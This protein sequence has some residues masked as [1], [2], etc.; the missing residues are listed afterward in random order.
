[1]AK[2]KV[3]VTGGAGFIGSHTV[4]ELANAGYEPIII[5]NFSNSEKQVIARLTQIT[6][7]PF[8][9]HELDCCNRD[10][11]TSALDSDVFGVIHFAA[12]K[13]VSASGRDPL[14]YYRNN[15][16]STTSLLSAMQQ[17]KVDNFVFSSSCTVY[18]QPD[19]LPVTEET[20]MKAAESVY[21]RTKQICEDIINDLVRSEKSLRAVT[22]RYFNPVGAHES[23][24]IGELPLGT[25]E[26]L[27]PYITQTAVG[28]RQQLTIFGNDYPTV[29]GTC[30]RDYIHVVDLAKAHVRALDWLRDQKPERGSFNEVFN[31]GT[32]RGTSVLEAVQAFERVTAKPLPYT[33]GPRRHGDVIQTYADATKANR[34][35]GWKAERSID[36]ALRDAYRWQVGLQQRS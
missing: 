4:V 9:V 12:F 27:L 30:V 8:T 18:G 6:G 23:A 31:L 35:L 21:G 5:D 33:I 14:G 17:K 25:P 24:L 22:L 11:L 29:D 20:P 10:A 1:M 34:V 16:G 28:L 7:R 13:S 15:L 3:V 2:P 19:V 36:D 26:N 32:G